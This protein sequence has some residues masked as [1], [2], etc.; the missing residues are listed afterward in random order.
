MALSAVRHYPSSHFLSAFLPVAFASLQPAAHTFRT[1]LWQRFP[2]LQTTCALPI[3]IGSGISSTLRDIWESVLRAVPK[4]KTTHSKKRHRQ[5]AGKAL[6]DATALNKCS[7]CGRQKRAHA[8]CPYCVQTIRQYWGNNW[9]PTPELEAEQKEK[10][11]KREEE[12]QSRK[13][14]K[15]LRWWP[16][17]R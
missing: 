7:G 13:R 6:Q 9:K 16:K 5:L 8:L 12:E 11:D 17:N 4:K 14:A 1:H 3:A 10:K 2:L 15:N